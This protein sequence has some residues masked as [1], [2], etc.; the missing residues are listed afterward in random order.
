MQNFNSNSSIYYS[1]N[2]FNYFYMK[3]YLQEIYKS[4]SKY[5]PHIPG[6]SKQEWWFEIVINGTFF[7][8]FSIASNN[9]CL[10][11]TLV[12]LN[13]TEKQNLHWFNLFKYLLLEVF[14]NLLILV[15]ENTFKK[16]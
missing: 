3:Y 4:L 5:V 2:H 13:H 6:S 12:L 8:R 11:C 14:W 1:L 9:I 15:K 10:L 7:F 16:L